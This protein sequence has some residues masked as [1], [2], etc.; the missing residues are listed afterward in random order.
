MWSYIWLPYTI[1]DIFW[2][3]H[4]IGDICINKSICFSKNTII[5][6]L[7]TLLLRQKKLPY[8]GLFSRIRSHVKKKPVISNT[9]RF[10]SFK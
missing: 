8:N 3:V 10:F 9:C 2:K 6:K 7:Y 5:Y 4:S 1:P